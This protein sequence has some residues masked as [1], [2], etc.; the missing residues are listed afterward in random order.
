M[1]LNQI[2]QTTKEKKQSMLKKSVTIVLLFAAVALFIFSGAAEWLVKMAAG[3][4]APMALET[5]PVRQLIT[6]GVEWTFSQASEEERI[7][8]LCEIST[9]AV[10][11]M[12][13]VRKVMDSYPG[14]TYSDLLIIGKVDEGKSPMR[15]VS[16][17]T[18][19]IQLKLGGEYMP[20]FND[21]FWSND[22]KVRWAEGLK[23]TYD[24][25]LPDDV[26][27]AY[28]RLEEANPGGELRFVSI[29][30]GQGSMRYVWRSIPNVQ[31]TLD[32]ATGQRKS[33][34]NP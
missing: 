5:D 3:T 21:S 25:V 27:T 19:E 23:T 20:D 28:V 32:A 7:E 15:S 29:M 16:D 34:P 12:A 22:E 24:P 2:P 8:Q 14:V 13:S 18:W 26:Y 11:D 4:S 6:Q 10:C 1:N 9:Q 33:T 17:Q 31:A 30:T